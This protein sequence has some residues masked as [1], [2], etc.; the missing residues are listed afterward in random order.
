MDRHGL[1]RLHPLRSMADDALWLNV[2]AVR[3]G[4][5]T[6]DDE[7]SSTTVEPRATK[8]LGTA[9]GIDADDE[10]RTVQARAA[11][12]GRR[13]RRQ[14]QRRGPG[15]VHPGTYYFCRS[16]TQTR[17]GRCAS[18]RSSGRGPSTTGAS[19]RR[20]RRSAPAWRGLRDRGL[21][22]S[23]GRLQLRRRALLQHSRALPPVTSARLPVSRGN[24]FLQNPAF[25]ARV[26]RAALC[27]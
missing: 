27:P 13:P 6:R 7:P 18:K 17:L 20:N 11:P 4:L 21:P 25:T 3:A 9:R 15:G 19:V 24:Q 1:W 10:R 12:G 5:V 26:L 2:N 22:R 8:V 16:K 23:L 14:H